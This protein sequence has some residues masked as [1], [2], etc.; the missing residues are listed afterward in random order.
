MESF[1]DF[2]SFNEQKTSAVEK[3]KDET[4][5]DKEISRS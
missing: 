5:Q 3:D 1:A 4:V 2:T